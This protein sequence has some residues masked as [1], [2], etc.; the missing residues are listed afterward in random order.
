MSD[1]PERRDPDHHRSDEPGRRD[2]DFARQQALK[3]A[4][5]IRT[6]TR[7]EFR[8]RGRWW[9]ACWLLTLA[10]SAFG[11][12]LAGQA[13]DSAKDSAASAQA[14]AAQAKIIAALAKEQAQAIQGERKRSVRSGCVDQN[15]RHDRAIGALDRILRAAIAKDPSGR[16]RLEAS[17]V[18]T[19][20][21]IDALAPKRNCTAAVAKAVQ[22]G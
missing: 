14:T 5:Q 1:R 10:L 15:R 3:I 21:L 18:S 17:R 7:A 20:L 2:E 19:V 4:H 11:L 8:R 12:F 13:G 9:F 6:E 22:S 16:A